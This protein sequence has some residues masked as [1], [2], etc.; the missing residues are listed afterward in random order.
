MQDTATRRSRLSIRSSSW[1]APLFS[2]APPHGSA[3]TG[4]FRPFSSC[5][6][7]FWRSRSSTSS[8]CSSPRPSCGPSQDCGGSS[9][10]AGGGSDGGVA[11][12]A[13][14][15]RVR[16]GLVRRVLRHVLHQPEAHRI[17]RREARASARP[18]ARLVGLALRHLGILRGE[19]HRRRHR[20]RPHRQPPDVAPPAGS[21]TAS[22]SPWGVRSPSSPVRNSCARSRSSRA[23]P[24]ESL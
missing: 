17:R 24:D 11:R 2:P 13:R 3:M 22:S 18:V 20:H 1:R 15:H 9:F 14:R 4:P 8:A 16:C 23:G 5:S 12:P 6:P 7:A 10:G 19:P 21:P